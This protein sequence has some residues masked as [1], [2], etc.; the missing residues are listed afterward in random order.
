MSQAGHSCFC[1]A[2]VNSQ[3]G[4]GRARDDR[5]ARVKSGT[6]GEACSLYGEIAR[7]CAAE[8]RLRSR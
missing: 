8:L 7:A 6:K 1:A 3:S 2:I 5:T 4:G